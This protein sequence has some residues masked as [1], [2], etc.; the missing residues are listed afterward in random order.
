MR[1]KIILSVILFVVVTL[2][3]SWWLYEQ[4]HHKVSFDFKIQPLSVKITNSSREEVAILDKGSDLQL[5][6][7][8][9]Y[10][11][12]NTEGIDSSPIPFTVQGR[13]TTI[14]VK[15]PQSQ[16]ILNQLLNQELEDIKATIIENYPEVVSQF[17][18]NRGQ[19]QH[20][21]DWYITTLSYKNSSNNNPRDTYKVALKKE[22]GIWVIMGTPQI[23]P[24]RHNM[25]G[26]PADI[27]KNA[28][29]LIPDKR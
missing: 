13:D 11:Y 22:E 9:Y 27:I 21:G 7:G 1:T 2:V 6:D 26:V 20:Q 4:G 17:N 25:P 16:V 14:V 28:Y 19:L 8:T 15:P 29:D 12:P 3:I 10:L 5:T 23:I 24:T 18:I